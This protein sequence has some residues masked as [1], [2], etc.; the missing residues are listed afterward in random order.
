MSIDVIGLLDLF[1]SAGWGLN[2][3]GG[4]TYLPLGNEDF[5]W[6]VL[7]IA[8]KEAVYPILV[9]KIEKGELI[10]IALVSEATNIGL[11]T[12][13]YPGLERITLSASINRKTIE[14]L[15]VTDFTWYLKEI[16]SVILE[17]GLSI[18]AIECT[19]G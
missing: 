16:G 2:D 10:G 12:L 6:E 18:E 15:D 1:Q 19:D 14:G 13:F 3:H 7:P 11:S 5:D 9:S 17:A 4:V 8:Q